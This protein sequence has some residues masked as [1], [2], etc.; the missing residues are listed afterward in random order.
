MCVVSGLKNFEDNN[1]SRNIIFYDKFYQDCWFL[2]IFIFVCIRYLKDF[3]FFDIV[4]YMS[5]T[6]IITFIW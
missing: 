3:I 2:Y 5:I 4:Y 1:I 6:F